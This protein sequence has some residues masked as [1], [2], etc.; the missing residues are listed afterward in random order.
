MVAGVGLGV[1]GLA[2]KYPKT[3]LVGA[4]LLLVGALLKEVSNEKH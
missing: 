1:V 4:G 3:A 2:K